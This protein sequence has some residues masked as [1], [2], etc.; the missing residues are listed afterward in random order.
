MIESVHSVGSIVILVTS[1][2]KNDNNKNVG[3]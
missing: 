2:D 1:S 3:T